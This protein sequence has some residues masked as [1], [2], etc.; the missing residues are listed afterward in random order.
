MLKNKKEEEMIA[1]NTYYCP[2]CGASN[3]IPATQKNHLCRY[4]NNLFDKEK[5]ETLSERSIKTWFK[6]K[7][8]REEM[9][10]GK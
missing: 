4:C 9:K 3:F 8:K 1:R 5:C 6:M 7:I 2:H 10:K